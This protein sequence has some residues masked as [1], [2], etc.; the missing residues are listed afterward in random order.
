M[1]DEEIL[2][3]IPL[4]YIKVADIHDVPDWLHKRAVEQMEQ[5]FIEGNLSDFYESWNEDVKQNFPYVNFAK[6]IAQLEQFYGV[7]DRIDRAIGAKA[8]PKV[9]GV[10][11]TF[12]ICYIENVRMFSLVAYNDKQE[13]VEFNYGRCCIYHPPEY[14]KE[15]RFERLELSEDPKIVIS[16]PTKAGDKYP[17][18]F[19]I[20]M[21]WQ[22]NVDG[23]IGY[24][25]IYKDYEYLSS[26]NVAFIRGEFTEDMLDAPEPA[27]AYAAA[28]MQQLMARSDITD[29]FIIF[30]GHGVLFMNRI[31]RKFGGVIKGAILINPAAK[32]LKNFPMVEYDFNQFPEDIPILLLNSDFDQIVE[33][34]EK[35]QW[36]KFASQKKNV[37]IKNYDHCDHMLMPCPQKLE[38]FEYSAYEFHMSDV[39][40]RDITTFIRNTK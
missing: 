3:T 29:I 38:G 39:A 17:A 8:H 13:V 18:A 10:I 5:V 31:L 22:L 12:V 36:I 9:P 2:S 4:P 35:D 6:Q 28:L 15:T 27:S 14:I 26:A 1:S 11:L 34:E 40:L 16:R 21:Q 7:V 25:F 23:R 33:Q 32:P 19:I 20:N 24:T 30:Q 37:T